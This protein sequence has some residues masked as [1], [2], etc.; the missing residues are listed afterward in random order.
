MVYDVTTIDATS[1]LWSP[2][3]ATTAKRTIDTV[4]QGLGAHLY[5]VTVTNSHGCSA[6]DS[7][8]VTF[9]DCTGLEELPDSR[10]IELYPNPSSG[11]FAI[12]SQAIP[13]GKYDL[14]IFDALGK[15]A[16][17][18]NGLTVSKNFIHELNL[19]HLSNGIYVLHLENKITGF[20]KRFVIHK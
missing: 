13:E 19:S 17:N 8:T 11:Q 3:G 16:Y 20:S 9:F 2:G 4:G 12:R 6:K 15:L 10:L 14:N 7:A 18:E 1:Y 5:S